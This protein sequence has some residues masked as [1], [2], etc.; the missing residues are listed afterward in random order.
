MVARM[1]GKRLF[2]ALAGTCATFVAVGSAPGA[3]IVVK[4]TADE[5]DANG[6]CSLREALEAANS[7]SAVDACAKGGTTRDTIELQAKRY[8][9]QIASTNED[10]NADGDLDVLGSV[11]I[12]GAGARK[13]TI[14]QLATDRIM[15][16]LN[17]SK[18]EVSR[19]ALVAGDVST[20]TPAE[21]RG[22]LVRAAGSSSSL[23]LDRA[24]LTLGTAQSG[25]AVYASNA[26]RVEA[27]RSLFSENYG[28]ARGGAI[29]TDGSATL[30]VKRS[31]FDD[32][33]ALSETQDVLGG[34]I[35][36]N[37]L[38]GIASIVDSTFTANR[39]S[40]SGTGNYT[41]GGA[42]Q[43]AGP[44]AVRGSTFEGNE[45]LALEDNTAEYGGAIYVG[46]SK[47]EVANSTFAA[48]DAF[49]SDGA[50]GAVY[51]AAGIAEL[52]HSTFMDN[53]AN[54]GDS[55]AAGDPGS[56]EIFG[57]LIDTGLFAGSI[58]D[59]PVGSSGFNVVEGDDADCKFGADDAT[60][61]GE[62]G[63][64]VLPLADYGGSTETFRLEKSS[65]AVNFV[66]KPACL[67]A[68]NGE[69]QRGYERPAGP[70]CEAGSFERGAKEP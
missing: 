24:R 60:G 55:L 1:A 26:S 6:K 29:A 21:G 67:K 64:G 31:N 19:T 51:A 63:I 33:A 13:T 61:S 35:S 9:L 54:M 50:G 37:A 59:G 17:T 45:V 43:T 42:I 7:N 49:D 32:N 23:E 53:Q 14:S 10:F 41:L 2:A 30:T 65:D 15:D 11:R 18:L 39:A 34:A 56:I 68:T 8:D 5:I 44:L 3:T 70:A 28:F 22:G 57:S 27:T 38:T 20:L 25:G 47:T 58:C 48:N 66:P 16:V 40:A 69:D 62:A 46:G 36:H 4:T 52:S 12:A